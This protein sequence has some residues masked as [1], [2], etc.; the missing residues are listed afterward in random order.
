MILPDAKFEHIERKISDIQA[1]ID[2]GLMDTQDHSGAISALRGARV[3]LFALRSLIH[4]SLEV[5]EQPDPEDPQ[6]A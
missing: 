3:E 6:A 4:E 1:K 2:R 5:R